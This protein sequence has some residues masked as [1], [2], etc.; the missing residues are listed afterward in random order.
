MNFRI[1]ASLNCEVA[2]LGVV[3]DY[4]QIP[5]DNSTLAYTKSTSV[6][7]VLLADLDI[8]DVVT[9]DVLALL[10]SLLSLD[11]SWQ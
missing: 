6:V 4:P 5:V 7:M 3:G 9:T 2:R 11:L 8:V 10:L 1:S